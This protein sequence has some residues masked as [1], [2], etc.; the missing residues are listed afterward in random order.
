[1]KVT[2][3]EELH[4][5]LLLSTLLDNWETLVVSLNNPISNGVLLLSIVKDS[6]LNDETRRK[7]AGIENA[8][9]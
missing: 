9:D 3:H 6:M 1:V 7:D 5:L 8:Q 2:L 4:A